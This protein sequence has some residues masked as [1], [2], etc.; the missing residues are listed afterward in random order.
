MIT[1]TVT[2][3]TV[4][5]VAVTVISDRSDLTER[6]YCWYNKALFQTFPCIKGISILQ[7]TNISE[8]ILQQLIIRC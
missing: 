5:F 2:V 4:G 3:I 6:R 8:P 1:I 7:L